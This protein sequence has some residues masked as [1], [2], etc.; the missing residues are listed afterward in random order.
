MARTR[1]KKSYRFHKHE[2]TYARAETRKKRRARARAAMQ[3]GDYD[4]A[5]VPEKGTEGRITW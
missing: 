3:R 1:R 2:G 5:T 4:A